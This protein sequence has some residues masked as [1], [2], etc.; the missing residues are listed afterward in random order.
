[1]PA[2]G[3]DGKKIMKLIPVVMVNGKFM[4]TPVSKPQTDPALQKP[5]NLTRSLALAQAA[6]KAVLDPSVTQQVINKVS[7]MNASS[8][9]VG[10]NLSKSPNKHPQQ[11][12]YFV[13]EPSST[14]TAPAPAANENP[15]FSSQLP[16]T[17]KSPALPRGQ[18]LQIPPNAQVRTVPGAELPPGIKKQIFTSLP[19]SSSGS[20][21]PNVVYVSPITT[22]SQSTAPSSDSALKL[23]PDSSYKYLSGALSHGPA[24]HLKLIPKA[25]Q[26]PNS[27]L[28]WVV[29]EEDSSVPSA[30]PPDSPIVTSE[31]LS[32]L[33]EREKASKR[34]SIVPKPPPQPSQ[35]KSAAG[36]D[37]ALV[38]CNGKVFFV[39]KKDS[40]AAARKTNP[41]NTTVLPSSRQSHGSGARVKRR[42]PGITVP[43]KSDEVIDLCDDDDAQED[44]SPRVPSVKMP[45]AVHQDEDNV[46]FVSYIPP[47]PESGSARDVL[48]K[49]TAPDAQ[50][51]EQRSADSLSSLPEPKSP[52]GTRGGED[53]GDLLA[54]RGR[55]PDQNGAVLRGS[56]EDVDAD[57]QTERRTV[58]NTSEGGSGKCSQQEEDT[59]GTEV[60]EAFPP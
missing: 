51:A 4:Q 37:D 50:R 60:R 56:A 25:P 16:V 39:A 22:V 21:L 47:K 44:S 6:K 10:V 8:N 5:V 40:C 2:V 3:A 20:G 19:S 13:L 23:P 24:K 58:P 53:S 57:A 33:A 41:F 27:P 45:A 14:A 30:L 11:Q 48:H 29:E 18:Y 9:H 17:V 49:D 46:I 1:M 31:I 12:N 26:R 28:K 38:V 55:T 52:A 59:H 32:A 54:L 15:R 36:H 43:D 7:L 42:N 34:C 35:G